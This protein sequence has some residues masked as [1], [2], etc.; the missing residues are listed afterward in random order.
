M[1]VIEI[2]YQKGFYSLWL[3]E[4]CIHGGLYTEE[5]AMVYLASY[6]KIYYVGWHAGNHEGWRDAMISVYVEWKE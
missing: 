3:N 4:E 2:R 6:E 1:S 5:S